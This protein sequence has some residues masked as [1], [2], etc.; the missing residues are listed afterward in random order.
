MD[1]PRHD[2]LAGTRLAGHQHGRVRRGHL[3]CLAQHRRAIRQTRRRPASVH[4][5]RARARDFARARRAPGP[6]AALRG[7][8]RRGRQ[9]FVGHGDGDV[10]GN[11]ASQRQ[12][13]AL[14]RVRVL[15]PEPYAEHQIAGPRG[16]G[17]QRPVPARREPRRSAHAANQRKVVGRQVTDNDVLGERRLQRMRLQIIQVGGRRLDDELTVPADEAH[18]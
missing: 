15:R 11:A 16:G 4:R 6:A 1:E 3:R 18:G 7:L 2:F 17:E 5:C 10:V 8:A 13:A 12:M 14:V 9:L